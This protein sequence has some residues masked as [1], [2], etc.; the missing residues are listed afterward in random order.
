MSSRQLRLRSLSKRLA[1]PSVW[2][3][4]LS[5][6]LLIAVVGAA[7]TVRRPT[8]IG[9]G[10]PKHDFFSGP[11][12]ESRQQSGLVAKP[13]WDRVRIAL[14]IKSKPANPPD[15]LVRVRDSRTKRIVRESTVN[16]S[17]RRTYPTEPLWVEFQF[18]PIEDRFPA[19]IEVFVLDDEEAHRLFIGTSRGDRFE[20]GSLIPFEPATGDQDLTFVYEGPESLVRHGGA[21][22]EHFM[23]Q[24]SGSSI[25]IAW[26]LVISSFVCLAALVVG[27]A[28]PSTV[29]LVISRIS[30]NLA[31]LVVA[32]EAVFLV[33]DQVASA[34]MLPVQP[35]PG[36]QETATLIAW[37]MVAAAL[38]VSLG[39]FRP[40][41][42]SHWVTAPAKAARQLTA[43]G[44]PLII[45]ATAVRA[46]GDA[47]LGG[48]MVGAAVVIL[49]FSVAL[50]AL[51][52]V[53]AR[54]RFHR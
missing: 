10:N 13:Y 51:S 54:W 34:E 47:P 24:A 26:A 6:A 45:I 12:I 15:V 48:A 52:A 53:A 7:A 49:T 16:I 35:A 14:T 32:A 25:A 23:K 18:R 1:E 29:W 19:T 44:V 31:L 41:A 9:L 22:V 4:I 11:L 50:A 17:A 39:R 2:Q 36:R 3:A 20:A 28:P 8:S 30:L 37:P 40:G 38:I 33:A 27:L 5:M 21:L 42:R 46:F 43:T